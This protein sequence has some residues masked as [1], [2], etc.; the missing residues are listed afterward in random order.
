MVIV[1]SRYGKIEG[2]VRVSELFHPDAVGISG[3]YGLG[4]LHSNP[5]NRIGPNF[6]TLLSLDE[7]TFDGV[8]GGQDSAPRVKLYKKE[9]RK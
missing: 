9:L 8:S 7:K 5:L 6:N 2:R 1:E 3:N 4:T